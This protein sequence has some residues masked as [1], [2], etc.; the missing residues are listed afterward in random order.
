MAIDI[1]PKK[2]KYADK[3]YSEF[4][5][6]YER[7]YGIVSATAFTPENFKLTP[8]YKF[9]VSQGKP[10]KEPVEKPVLKG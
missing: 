8:H 9:W 4:I 5:A 7:N 2:G 1:T 6:W 10:T 3:E